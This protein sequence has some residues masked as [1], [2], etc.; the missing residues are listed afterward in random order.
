MV[1]AWIVVLAAVLTIVPRFAGEFNVEFSTPGT[2]SQAAT[3]LIEAHFP[4]NS[5]DSVNVVWEA[6]AGARGVQERVDRFLSQAEKLEDIGSASPPRYSRDGTIGLAQLELEHARLSAKTESGTQL[7]ALAEDASGDGLRIELGGSLI[8]Q[9]QE[10]AAPEMVGLLG[11]AIVLLIAFGSVVAAGL[12]LL[13][14]IFGLG[15]SAT[16]IGIL[17]SLR[18]HAGVRTGRRR[19]DRNRRRDRLLVAHTHALSL[20]ADRR[21]GCPG[22]ARRVDLDGRSQ[23]DR[24]RR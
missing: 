15:I 4:R 12:P 5:G 16:L 1:L 7:I 23:R 24:R 3:D 18:R 17:V 6:P 13:V 19:P 22:G 21:S 2:E 8:Q 11:A 10:R 9:A 14:A 20:R